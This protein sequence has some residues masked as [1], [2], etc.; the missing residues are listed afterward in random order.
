MSSI[1]NPLLDLPAPLATGIAPGKAHWLCFAFTG[2]FVGSLYLAESLF[3][4]KPTDK[5]LQSYPPPG[6][7][8]HPET[9]KLR[10]RAVGV[11]TGL[12]VLGVYLTVAKE[13]EHSWK[14]AV[15]SDC[16]QV[17]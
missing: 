10:M 15:S 7:R 8:D 12:A 17:R 3:G 9:M 2:G 16:P 1:I 4:K 5:Q 13:G 6:H 14:A 11:A